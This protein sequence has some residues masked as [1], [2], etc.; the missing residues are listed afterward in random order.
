MKVRLLGTGGADGIPGFYS[1]SRVSDYA[2]VHGGKEI[3][4]RCAALIDGV[5]KIDFGPD[6]LAQMQ[7]DRLDARDWLA[8][9]FT[10]SHDDHCCLTQLQYLVHPFNKEEVFPFPMYCNPGVAAKILREYENWPIEVL[11]TRSFEPFYVSDYKITSVKA[12]HMIEED[13][14]NPIFEKDGKKILYATD[15]GIWPDISWEF[16]ADHKLDGLVI[17]ATDGKVKTDYWGHM[18]VRECIEV[19]NRLRGMGVVSDTTQIVTTHHS[20]NGDMTYQEL[21]DVLSQHGIHAGFD[22][23]ELDV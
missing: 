1:D 7:R 23:I 15:T 8:V 22:G 10:H 2:R 18:D 12:N 13:A 17:E 3:R 20:H 14:Q 21:H 5:L 4:T 11:T 19:V 9:I 16:L 6:T